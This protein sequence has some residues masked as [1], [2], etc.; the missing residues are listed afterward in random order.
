MPLSRKGLL[1][2]IEGPDGAGKTTQAQMLQEKLRS[3]GLRTLLTREPGGTPISEEVRR[4]IL[5]PAFGEMTTLCEVFL[6]CAARV[7]LMHEVIRPALEEGVLVIS[8]RFIDSNSVYQGFAGGEDPEMI[9]KLNA[10][11]TGGFLPDKT[12]LLD[13]PAEKGLQRLQEKQG[14]KA[15]GLAD[16]DRMEQKDLD[17][18]NRVRDGFLQVAQRDPLRVSIIDAGQSQEEVSKAIWEQME[19]LLARKNF[20]RNKD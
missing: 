14:I 16:L 15:A 3:L 4:I 19:I 20:F 18:H 2:S 17:F 7:Q 11:V 10:W 13:L 9:E 8:D 5:S 12:F 1:V 6:F